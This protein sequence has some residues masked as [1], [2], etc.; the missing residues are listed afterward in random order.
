MN[1]CIFFLLFAFAVHAA[2]SQ[3]CYPSFADPDDDIY[4][5]SI[6]DLF[7]Y[8]SSVSTSG[9]SVYP[10]SLF[11]TR[12]TLGLSYLMQ[13]MDKT[14]SGAG[15]TYRIWIDFNN[16]SIFTPNENIYN[17]ANFVHGFSFSYAV[18][19]DVTILGKRKLRII[20]AYSTSAPNAC[21][22]FGY[23][24]CEDY[25]IEFTHEPILP[26]Y[27]IP[28]CTSPGSYGAGISSFSFHTLHNCGSGKSINS[29]THYPDSLYST[30]LEMGKAYYLLVDQDGSA[31]V[32]VYLDYN[33]DHI[34]G[35]NELLLSTIDEVSNTLISIQYDSSYVGKRRLRVIST[36]SAVPFN[37]CVSFSSGEVEDYDI[38]IT[39]PLPDSSIV[40]PPNIW[41]KNYTITGYQWPSK[42]VE[43]YDK[44]YLIGGSNGLDNSYIHL[45]K[46]S[47]DGD[48]LQEKTII[49]SFYYFVSGMDE[50][51]DG[52][53]I[54][55]GYTDEGAFGG[56]AGYLK[57]FTPCRNLEWER[58]YGNPLGAGHLK[59]VYQ[60][61]DS[62]FIACGSNMFPY[63]ANDTGRVCL[64][65]TDK[66]GNQ[67]W[68]K[69]LTYF[70]GSDI[71]SFITTRDCGG[72][73]SV[74]GYSVFLNDTTGQK[75]E[76][77]ILT[78]V[79][80]L[81]NLEW[82]LVLDTG[83]I[84]NYVQSSVELNDEGFI[85][86]GVTWDK[87]T[88]EHKVTMFRSSKDG[89]LIQYKAHKIPGYSFPTPEVIRKINDNKFLVLCYDVDHCDAYGYFGR[90]SLML[91]DSCL[92]ITQFKQLGNVGIEPQDAIINSD[93]RIVL[94]AINKSKNPM[95]IYTAKINPNDLN[96]DSLYNVNL[97]Y[98]S[99][100]DLSE[101]MDQISENKQQVTFW[102]N[103]V[104]DKVTFESG[105]FESP[106]FAL[107]IY[108][109]AGNLVN[110]MSEINRHEVTVSLAEIP[111]GLYFVR[112][113]FPNGE[114]VSS[115]IIRM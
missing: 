40:L 31:R 24:E 28:I 111:P 72:L 16:D 35:T 87:I 60:T 102:P 13:G 114:H 108:N 98:D 69:D 5:F 50:T 4:Y 57:K 51:Y 45:V 74:R 100:C 96:F 115:K 46:T 36:A 14:Q 56:F 38:T 3:P 49:D 52:G 18:P 2:G 113:L 67:L 9:V 66:D 84:Y 47:I 10:D 15:T 109:T 68:L 26:A 20:A 80:S 71:T 82:N 43:T 92:N 53:S 7:N 105:N 48:L 77:G 63:M 27:C 22:A 1:R 89:K 76:R 23:G 85:S 59:E 88:F 91:I 29:Y 34:F 90:T 39:H 8:S 19:A 70:Y 12:L 6:N 21:G 61:I 99:L 32:K 107:E 75:I 73:I 30:I 81:G 110:S 104:T 95:G 86:V 97:I 55:A 78:K 106:I 25:T 101:G 112:V 65:R 93:G 83:N 17:S 11:T 64:L 44:G 62:G 37:A 42:I 54:V 33:N 94:V 58:R 41:E 103:P 79:D